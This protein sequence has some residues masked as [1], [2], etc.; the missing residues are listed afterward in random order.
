MTFSNSPIIDNILITHELLH[1]LRTRKEGKNHHLTFKLDICKAFAHVEWDF[2]KD[3]MK[4]LDFYPSFMSWIIFYISTVSF[5]YVIRNR[6]S[7]HFK[8]LWGIKQRDPFSLFLFVLCSEE[9][10][11][12]FRQVEL[13]KKTSRSQ[14]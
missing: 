7:K 5:S 13:D 3:I 12:L 6:V 10:I 11:C 2:L 14:G 8:P 9:F 1:H 4:K